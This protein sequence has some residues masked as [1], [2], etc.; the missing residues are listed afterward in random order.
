MQEVGTEWKGSTSQV[1][2]HITSAKLLGAM[3]A[4]ELGAMNASE[5]TVNVWQVSDFVLVC[6]L[7]K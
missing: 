7:P 6:T 5:P 1:S 3:N 4:S 2:T